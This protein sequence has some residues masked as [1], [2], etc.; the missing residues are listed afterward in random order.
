MNTI[1]MDLYGLVLAGGQSTRMGKDKAVIDYHGRPQLD[2]ACELLAQCC[3]KVFVSTRHARSADP[4]YKKFPQLHDDAAFEGKGPLAGIL[5]A[6]K[7]YPASAWMILACDLPFVTHDTVEHLIK[8]RDPS[9]IATA[10]KSSHDGLPEPLCAIWE[11]G[12][13]KDILQMFS[14]GILCPRKVLIS[15]HAHILESSNPRAL[16]NINDFGQY[17]EALKDLGRDELRGVK[18]PLKD[19]TNSLDDDLKPFSHKGNSP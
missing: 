6:M 19:D 11:P 7:A 12:Y 13:Y 4:I 3:S 17:K 18:F 1:H 14:Q 16:T 2:V 5:S 10:Y 8:H 9:K 15:L